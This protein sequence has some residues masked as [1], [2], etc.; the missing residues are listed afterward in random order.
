MSLVVGIFLIRSLLYR[1]EIDFILLVVG[2]SFLCRE[3]HFPGTDTAVVIV[4]V[5]AFVWIICK[6]DHILENINGAK[7]VQI[8]L[9]GTF[10]TYFF[11]I[12]IQRN[13]FSPERLPFLSHIDLNSISLEE[14]MENIAHMYFLFVGIASFWS[15]RRNG[16]GKLHQEI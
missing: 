10:F 5:V 16:A 3:I 1:L 7:V 4:A 2:V 8:G 9:T 6:K 15:I 14:V 12:L 13:V 11:A